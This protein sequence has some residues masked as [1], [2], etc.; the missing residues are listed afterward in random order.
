MRGRG[1]AGA[2]VRSGMTSAFSIVAAVGL[3][4]GQ[5]GAE[6]PAKQAQ[7]AAPEAEVSKARIVETL[8]SLPTKRAS[9]GDEAHRKYRAEWNTRR[10]RGVAR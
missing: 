10:V 6:A 8:R 7:I 5:S 9:W 1:A 3:A 2:V 4:C